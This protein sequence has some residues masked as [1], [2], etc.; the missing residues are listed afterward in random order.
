MAEIERGRS[1]RDFIAWS[2]R[3]SPESWEGE[4]N[5]TSAWEERPRIWGPSL[6]HCGA[7]VTQA[8]VT[9]RKQ[10]LSRN[11]PLRSDYDTDN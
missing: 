5:S 7:S 8:G 4:I 3:V 9:E 10:S 11:L 1:R 6:I 2:V